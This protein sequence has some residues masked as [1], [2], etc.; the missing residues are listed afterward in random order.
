MEGRDREK[1]VSAWMFGGNFQY[2]IHWVVWQV[3][4]L[5]W[6]M[7]SQSGEDSVFLNL[8][9]LR[10]LWAWAPLPNVFSWSFEP[11]PVLLK[12]C[13]TP[14][15]PG[16][17]VALTHFYTTIIDDW[18]LYLTKRHSRLCTVTLHLLNQFAMSNQASMSAMSNKNT[19]HTYIQGKNG[20][21]INVF[22]LHWLV[23]YCALTAAVPPTTHRSPMQ[24]LCLNHI[25]TIVF[26][27]T[28]KGAWC[29]WNEINVT[30]V[31]HLFW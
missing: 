5:M 11:C 14:H 10:L 3:W 6:W 18:L 7:L 22:A 20:R 24:P 19:W 31:H 30:C 28:E 13:N 17:Y 2:I 9:S 21:L 26:T 25:F 8:G 15:A 29:R 4:V 23:M 12:N 1:D 16:R 27:Q